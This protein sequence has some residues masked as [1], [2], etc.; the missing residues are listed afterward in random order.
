[1]VKETTLSNGLRI[2]TDEMND[3]ETVSMGIWVSVGSRFEEPAISGISHLLEHMAFKGTTGR[4]GFKN[5]Q[6]VENLGGV[7]YS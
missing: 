7:F 6:E 2:I 3:V 5:S 1:M 4:S